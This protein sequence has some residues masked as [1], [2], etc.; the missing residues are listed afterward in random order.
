VDITERKQ[1]EQREAI[2][3]AVQRYL[4]SEESLGEAIRG[5]MRVMCERLD[6]ACAAR[7]SLDEANNRLHCVE[8]WSEDD[9]RI[10]AFLESSRRET[11]VPGT[12]GM[13]RRVLTTGESVWVADVLEKKDLMRGPMAA[14]A[15]LRGPSRCRCAWA[16][17]CW[18]RSNSSRMSRAIRTN[19]CSSRR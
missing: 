14:Q 1:A 11:F 16:T 12:T 18:A 9:D 6:W 5:I 17:R 13:I 10:R 7:W 15:G 2:E 19:G 8:T 3:H 4:G